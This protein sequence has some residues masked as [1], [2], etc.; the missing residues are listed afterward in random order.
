MRRCAGALPF[1]VVNTGRN[2][3]APGSPDRAGAARTH[4]THAF[5]HDAAGN[6]V[7]V[8]QPDGPRASRFYLAWNPSCVLGRVRHDVPPALAERLAARVGGQAA[9]DNL[10][11][12]RRHYTLGLAMDLWIPQRE[13]TASGP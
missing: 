7:D 5:T 13:C 11:P 4:R 3:P 10:R 1:G 12:A 2:D 8:N 9:S 6:L